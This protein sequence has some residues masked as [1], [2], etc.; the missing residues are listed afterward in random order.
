MNKGLDAMWFTVADRDVLD[1]RF[2][3]ASKREFRTLA[4]AVDEVRTR[5]YDDYADHAADVSGSLAADFRAAVAAL[6]GGAL[7]VTWRGTRYWV[8]EEHE[9]TGW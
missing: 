4:E 8:S 1:D 9:E 5:L 6:D 2:G 3:V 7:D